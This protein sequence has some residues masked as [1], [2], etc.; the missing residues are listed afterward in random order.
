MFNS[1]QVIEIPL[2]SFGG[3]IAI[4]AG[5]T[6]IDISGLQGSR[7]T[8]FLSIGVSGTVQY[9]LN[10]GGYRTAPQGNMGLDGASVNTLQIY[11]TAGSTAILQLNGI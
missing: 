7:C 1:E 8:G 5:T 4:S 6:N 11:A 9:S 10:G 2:V 3:D